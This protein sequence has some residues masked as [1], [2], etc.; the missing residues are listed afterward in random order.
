MREFLGKVADG[1]V[2][3]SLSSDLL[4]LF[5]CIFCKRDWNSA[6]TDS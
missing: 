3:F 5:I 6:P 1:S 2:H 4:I